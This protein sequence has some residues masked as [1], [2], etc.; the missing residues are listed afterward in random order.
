MNAP[1]ISGPHTHQ[2]RSVSRIMALV[3]LALLPAT[4]FGFYSFGWPAIYLFAVTALSTVT[5]NR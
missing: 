4:L 5:A 1:V 2:A 3:M